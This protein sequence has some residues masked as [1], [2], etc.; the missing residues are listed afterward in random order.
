MLNCAHEPKTTLKI[1]GRV[2]AFS[3]NSYLKI[4]V[5]KI[6]GLNP[7]PPPML[8][9]AFSRKVGPSSPLNSSKGGGGGFDIKGGQLFCP[10]MN[11]GSE[12]FFS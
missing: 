1:S 11:A 6:I 12:R 5:P 10:S 7:P 2:L 8:L 3:F 9:H 4:K